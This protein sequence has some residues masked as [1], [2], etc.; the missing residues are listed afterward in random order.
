MR[1]GCSSPIVSILDR[2]PAIAKKSNYSEGKINHFLAGF[3]Q[4]PGFFTKI[5][6][7]TP[8]IPLYK[9]GFFG[10]IA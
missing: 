10:I 8:L 2:Q 4:K 9:P 3:T 6:P 1:A 5:S 7:R